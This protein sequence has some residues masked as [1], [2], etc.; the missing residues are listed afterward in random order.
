MGEALLSRHR[1]NSGKR[2]TELL[3]G[4]LRNTEEE[5]LLL[6]N[7]GYRQIIFREQGNS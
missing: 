4:V 7:R 5:H 1:S 6:G 2:I 3:P